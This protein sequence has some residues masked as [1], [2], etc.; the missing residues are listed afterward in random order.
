MVEALKAA[1]LSRPHERRLSTLSCVSRAGAEEWACGEQRGRRELTELR[2]RRREVGT[3]SIEEQCTRL[4]AQASG[5]RT[6]NTSRVRSAAV[7]R[8]QGLWASASLV[9][10]EQLQIERAG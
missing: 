5:R 4:H 1:V 9:S 10:G 6:V 2:R 8:V 7:C 3:Y